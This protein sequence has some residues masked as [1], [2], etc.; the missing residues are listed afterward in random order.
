MF[1]HILPNIGGG[2]LRTLEKIVSDSNY[3]L[4]DEIDGNESFVIGFV[5]SFPEEVPV[6]KRISIATPEVKIASGSVNTFSSEK[7][8]LIKKDQKKKITLGAF[9]VEQKKTIPLTV[10]C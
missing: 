7:L 5:D 3:Y 4:S 2:L 1:I 10:T 8:E 9:L 6:E